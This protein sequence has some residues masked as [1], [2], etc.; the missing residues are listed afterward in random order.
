VEVLY[1]VI[2]VKLFLNFIR[3]VCENV[4]YTLLV[5]IL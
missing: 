3:T 1:V 5:Y 4:I 2:L